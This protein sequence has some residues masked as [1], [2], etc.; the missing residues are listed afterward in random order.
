M[1]LKGQAS[2]C[3]RAKQPPFVRWTNAERTRDPRVDKPPPLLL[4]EWG[5]G[6]FHPPSALQKAPYL[7]PDARAREN[8]LISAS[9][10]VWGEVFK[11]H[12]MT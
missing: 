1:L 7:S 12:T 6:T 10:S 5:T 8:G 4:S 2:S 9:S 11:S 3:W